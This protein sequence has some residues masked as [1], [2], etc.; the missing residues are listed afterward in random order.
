MNILHVVYSLVP[1]HFRGGIPK[2]VYGLA[3]AQAQLG[4]YVLVYTTNYNSD[5]KFEIT[6]HNRFLNSEGVFIHYFEATRIGTLFSPALRLAMEDNAS[7]FDVIHAHNLFHP[8]N[9]YAHRVAKEHRIPVYYSIHGSLDPKVLNKGLVKKIKKHLYLKW[10]ELPALKQAAGVF[11]L[12][13]EEETQIRRLLGDSPIFILP[14]GIT[15]TTTPKNVSPGS[16]TVLFV[17]RIHPKKGLHH[18]LEAFALVVAKIPAA[19]LRIGGDRG[20]SPG[21]TKQLED[22]V[23]RYNL[24]EHICWLGF[25]NEKE[26][27]LHLAEADIFCLLS[28]SE[29]MAMVV[30]E[31]MSAGLTTV[32]SKGCYMARAVQNEAVVECDPNRPDQVADCL[33]ELISNPQKR[34]NLEKN[35]RRYVADHHAWSI[36]A[37]ASIVTYRQNPGL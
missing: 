36:I 3:K 10:F 37:E 7:H 30:L 16:P 8:L 18:L 35:A 32:V 15:P 25:L 12:S 27:A 28:E 5:Q 31:S 19:R 26:K 22:L 2:S 4:H 29:G 23:L 20:Q 33:I 24:Q 13:E 1:G 14:N 17:G 6:Q 11:A 34:M 21:Y 9:R